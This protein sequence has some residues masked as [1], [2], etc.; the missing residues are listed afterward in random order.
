MREEVREESN[1]GKK[2][3]DNT[4]GKNTFISKQNAKIVE[5]CSFSHLLEKVIRFQK[6]ASNA[7]SVGHS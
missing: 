3:T 7:L 2:T 5:N 4:F 6:Y 1:W